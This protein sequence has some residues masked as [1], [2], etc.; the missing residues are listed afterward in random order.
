VPRER[1]DFVSR[2]GNVFGGSKVT[3][4]GGGASTFEQFVQQFGG[5]EEDGG[6]T[7]RR[8]ARP[9]GGE[10]LPKVPLASY[11]HGYSYA[12]GRYPGG[13]PRY[14]D[15]ADMLPAGLPPHNI[16]ALQRMMVDSGLLKNPRYGFWDEESQDAYRQ[17]LHESNQKGTDVQTLLATYS[18]V[19]AAAE[20][21][22]RGPFVAPA[23][24][25]KTHNPKDLD[26][27]FRK[28]V[29]ELLGEGWSQADI[30]RAR[31]AY[32][33]EET[34]IQTDAQMQQIERLRQEY[35]YKGG[36]PAPTIDKTTEVVIRDP[37]L[38]IED[39]A[40]RRDPAGYQATQIAEDFA[41]A[42]FQA[43]QGYGGGR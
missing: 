25:I 28:S 38:Y 18:E 42:F 22:A 19:A 31:N 23:L 26:A 8:A 21:E 3:S 32:I 37:N 1:D 13:V 9:Y 6:T 43:L 27:V 30:E 34:R 15:G 2:V 40:K 5:G 16:A 36:G 33:A 24:E 29:I 39:E 14:F 41:P 20:A 35:E 11:A 17:A 4:G 7:D 12:Q 10:R